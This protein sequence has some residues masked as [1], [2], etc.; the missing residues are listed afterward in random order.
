MTIGTDQNLQ[1]FFVPNVIELLFVQVARDRG[2]ILK[3]KKKIK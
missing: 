2:R 3:K 1:L